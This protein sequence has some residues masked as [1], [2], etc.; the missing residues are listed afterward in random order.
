[1]VLAFRRIKKKPTGSLLSLSETETQMVHPQHTL[2][3][4]GSYVFEIKVKVRLSLW[5]HALREEIFSKWRNA[6]LM[7]CRWR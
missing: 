7:L 5:L 3:H 6:P 1:M 2:H 4:P